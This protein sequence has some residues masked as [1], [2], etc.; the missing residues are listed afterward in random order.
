MTKINRTILFF[1]G[2][3][4]ISLFV[5]RTQDVNASDQTIALSPKSRFDAYAEQNL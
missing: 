5:F 4:F 2:V 1:L 3:V